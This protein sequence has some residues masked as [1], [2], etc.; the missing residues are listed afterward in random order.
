LNKQINLFVKGRVSKLYKQQHLKH[1]AL[2]QRLSDLGVEA[3]M[4]GTASRA[5]KSMALLHQMEGTKQMLRAGLWDQYRDNPDVFLTLMT[6]GTFGD[7][8]P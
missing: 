8:K 2:L 5:R 6:D 7:A 1:T 3:E 4:D